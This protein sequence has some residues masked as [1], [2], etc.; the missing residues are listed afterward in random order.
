MFPARQTTYVFQDAQP[1]WGDIRECADAQKGRTEVVRGD[2][3]EWVK[4]MLDM[5]ERKV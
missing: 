4:T 5:S 3:A 2:G 1:T